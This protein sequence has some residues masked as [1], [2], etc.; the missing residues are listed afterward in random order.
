MDQIARN[1][2]DGVKLVE[3]TDGLSRGFVA[4]SDL[5]V[6]HCFLSVPHRLFLTVE[7]ALQSNVGRLI[8]ATQNVRII[9]DLDAERRRWEEGGF[10]DEESPAIMV[11]RRSVLYAYLIHLRH[12]AKPGDGL[13]PYAASLPAGFDTA[14]S[15]SP[16]DLR[17][18]TIREEVERLKIH[19]LGQFDSL[20]PMMSH[21]HPDAFPPG[22]FT[23]E[24]WM[25]A[26]GAYSSRC[27]PAGVFGDTSVAS[28]K[29]AAQDGVMVPLCDMLNHDHGACNGLGTCE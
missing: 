26:H 25:W 3:G 17:H 21:L 27:F 4:T 7:V 13:Q 16:S 1:T 18:V 14:F 6:G 10:D 20:F 2:L 5:P 19:L 11:T 8:E 15:W 12:I 24:A 23:R 29:V 9:G 28:A 22:V